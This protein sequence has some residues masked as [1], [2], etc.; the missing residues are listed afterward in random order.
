MGPLPVASGRDVDVVGRAR[1]REAAVVEVQDGL[2]VARLG[3]QVGRTRGAARSHALRREVGDIE[4]AVVGRAGWVVVGRERIAREHAATGG[5]AAG[6]TRRG[7][8]AGGVEQ[9]ADRH[10]L[11]GRAD[12]DVVQYLVVILLAGDQRE[13]RR[14]LARLRRVARPRFGARAGGGDVR[15]AGFVDEFAVVGNP[16][17]RRVVGGE[18]EIV[19]ARDGRGEVSAQPFAGVVAVDRV[20]LQ[21]GE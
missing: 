5:P 14:T 11:R 7:R 3:A 1:R 8:L 10:V 12:A 9:P 21:R 2:R 16:E 6:R 18:P 4:R 15:A 19:I 17:F 13:P 20:V